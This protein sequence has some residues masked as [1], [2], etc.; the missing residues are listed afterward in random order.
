M[1]AI[2]YVSYS[3]ELQ[4]EEIIEGQIRECKEYIEKQGITVL[5]SYIYRSNSVLSVTSTSFA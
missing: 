5:S 2:I 4:R 3:T 1:K